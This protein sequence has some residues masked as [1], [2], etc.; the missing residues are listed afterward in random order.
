M[1]QSEEKSLVTVTTRDII[2]ECPACSKSLV[3]DEAAE[4]QIVDCPQCR[5]NLIVPPKPIIASAPPPSSSATSGVIAA[6]SSLDARIDTTRLIELKQRLSALGNQ[7]KELQTQR[8]EVNNR[9]ASRINEINRDLL[10]MARIDTSQ[11]QLLSE[12]Q[13]V[14]AQI[15]TAIASVT[16]AEK[17]APLGSNVGA[18]RTRVQFGA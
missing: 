9:F 13:Q 7:L 18:G 6:A 5:I 15:G 3:V 11:Q 2:F 1:K 16:V 4:G 8:S 17:T 12:W 14:I 10:M